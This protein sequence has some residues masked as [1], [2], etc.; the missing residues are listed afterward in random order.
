MSQW[1]IA[2]VTLYCIVLHNL[3]VPSDINIIHNI[4]L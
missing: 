1:Y 2:A 4:E 3:S